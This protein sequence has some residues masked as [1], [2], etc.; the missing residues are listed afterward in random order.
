M[1][2][3]GVRTD[4]V[5]GPGGSITYAQ[6]FALQPFG[7]GLVVQTLTGAQLKQ[8]LEQ[9][10]QN[11]Q[12]LSPSAGFAFAYDPTAPAGERLVS[13]SFE[14][15][16][17]DPAGSYRIV[18][19]SFMASGGDNYTMLRDGTD[20]RD[21]GVDLDALEAYL[22]AGKMMP[23]GGRVRKVGAVPATPAAA[24]QPSA[25]NSARSSPGRS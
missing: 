11:V 25:I 10:F 2:G 16:P 3:G 15:R 7:N 18:T 13:A 21:V 6:I 20:R 5:P 4:L 12:M 9:Q 24:P 14:G 8:L 22:A 1:N 19:N 23:V 17:I